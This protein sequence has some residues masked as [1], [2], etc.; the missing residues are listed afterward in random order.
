[1][2]V[3][4]VFDQV[5]GMIPGG[6]QL[7]SAGVAILKL[8]LKDA[9][10]RAMADDGPQ[11]QANTIRRVFIHTVNDLARNLHLSVSSAQDVIN[12]FEAVWDG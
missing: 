2:V 9:L 1:M 4:A 10:N 8:G 11:A 7:A 6:G 5:W 12:G 3:G